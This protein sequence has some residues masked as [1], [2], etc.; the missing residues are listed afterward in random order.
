MR[1][2]ATFMSQLMVG[3][4]TYVLLIISMLMT[5]ML[6]LR[7]FAIAAG[8]VGAVYTWFWLNDPISTTWEIIFV[9]VNIVQLAIAGYRNAVLTFSPD[10]RAFYNLMVPSL[11]PH[12]VRRLLRI[13]EWRRAESGDRLIE[14]GSMNPHLIFVRSGKVEILHEG[15]LVGFCGAGSLVGEISAADEEPATATVTVS[16]EVQYL[17]FDRDALRKLKRSDPIIGQAIENCSRE[18]L[19]NKLVQMNVAAAATSASERSA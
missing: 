13:A 12:Q 6:W 9:S 15:K 19:K 3:N 1:V 8:V 4:L 16:E 10:E 5:R 14:Q 2:D 17:A 11:E 18:S 7:I